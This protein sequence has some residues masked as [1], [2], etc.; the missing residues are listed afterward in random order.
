MA[1]IAIPYTNQETVERILRVAKAKIKIGDTEQDDMT[2]GDVDEYILDASKMIDSMLRKIVKNAQ[3]P[4][5]SYT[6]YPEIMYAAPRI[7]AFLIYRDMFRAFNDEA[8]PAGP[9]GWLQEAKDFIMVFIDNVNSGVYSLL[10][11][12]TTGPSWE[13]ASTFFQNEIGVEEVNDMVANVTNSKPA[14][15]NN[16]TPFSNG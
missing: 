12:A 14:V 2:T 11:P 7:T 1:Y 9:Q 3:I 15:S 4:L 13:T 10:S 5:I 16:I 6:E 8:L